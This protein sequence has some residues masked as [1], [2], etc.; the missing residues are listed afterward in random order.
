MKGVV[1]FVA[2]I[3]VGLAV[4]ATLAQG[5]NHGLVGLNHVGVAVPDLD[6]AVAYYTKTLGRRT[7]ARQR[8]ADRDES[9]RDSRGEHESGDGDVQAK[10]SQ[11]LRD[12][13][14]PHKGYSFEHYRPERCS[15]R[16]R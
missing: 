16:A 1:L 15:H 6:K 5:P 8:S 7:A 9:F 2:G 12:P 10:R 4:Q 13:H 11:R 3:L 14:Q